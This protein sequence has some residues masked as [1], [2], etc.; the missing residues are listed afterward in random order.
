MFFDK[1]Y[2]SSNF[3]DRMMPIDMILLH[4]T[5]MK[6]AKEALERLCLPESQVSAHY[7][8]DEDGKVFALIDEDKRAWH[9]GVSLWRGKRDTNSRS[10]GI[11]LVN[12]GHEFGYKPFPEAQ[13]AAAAELV[14]EIADRH[15]VRPGFILGHS[16][17]APAR[18]A[19][20]GELFPWKRLAE[21]GSGIWTDAFSDSERTEAE[22][23]E[24]IGYDVSDLPAAVTAFR[25]HFLPEALND[26]D[27]ERT[28][29]RL[30]AVT[31]LFEKEEKNG[32]L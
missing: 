6:S 29:K 10:I 30:A 4:Y 23:L 21:Q 16:D 1:T 3:S 28:K 24:T 2:R 13:F 8:I 20:P 25:R 18:K 27:L 14:R 32:S 11:E 5:G 26:A 15:N 31:A 9:A 19:D 17:V 7:V 12:P 22:M